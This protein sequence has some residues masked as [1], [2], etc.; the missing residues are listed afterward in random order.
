MQ[1]VAEN[2]VSSLVTP[3]LFAAYIG[4]TPSA[5]RKMVAAGKL[6]VVRM[7]DPANPTGQ[8]EIYIHKDEWDA[9]ASHLAQVAPP[10]WHAWKDRLFTTEIANLRSKKG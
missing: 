6:P 2:A 7:K 9:Y 4:K 3:E 8:G 5:I 10:E 1:E